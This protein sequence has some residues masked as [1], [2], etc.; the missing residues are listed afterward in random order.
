MCFKENDCM[1]QQGS[2]ILFYHQGKVDLNGFLGIHNEMG[3]E[4]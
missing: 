1:S 3:P 2:F 4:Y